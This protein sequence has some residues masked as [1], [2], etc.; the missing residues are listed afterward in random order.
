MSFHWLIVSFPYKQKGCHNTFYYTGWGNL[1]GVLNKDLLFKAPL[2]SL[3]KIMDDITSRP[4]VTES[5]RYTVLSFGL[6]TLFYITFDATCA[7]FLIIQRRRF[8]VNQLP[9][10]FNPFN[11]VC[12]SLKGPLGYLPYSNCLKLNIKITPYAQVS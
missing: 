10:D 5:S 2:K 11:V 8:C 1:N 9:N 4:W 3:S 7:I 12:V 6:R